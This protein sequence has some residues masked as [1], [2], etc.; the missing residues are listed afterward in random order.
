MA[1][2]ITGA[3]KRLLT[4]PNDVLYTPPGDVL[5]ATV[6]SGTVENIL[7][8]A[9]KLS[10]KIGGRNTWVIKEKLIPSHRSPLILPPITLNP[11]EWLETW[12]DTANALDVSLTIGEQR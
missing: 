9:V 6:A 3:G 11:G 1:I 2:K 12:S 7:P 4:T 10:I 5:S 8:T